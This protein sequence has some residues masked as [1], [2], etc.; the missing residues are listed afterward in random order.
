M[1]ML[2]NAAISIYI[3]LFMIIFGSNTCISGVSGQ[4]CPQ[5]MSCA[6]VP[7]PS[8]SICSVTNGVGSYT[9]GDSTCTGTG[10]VGN[11]ATDDPNNS[12]AGV[13][14]DTFQF[15]DGTTNLCDQ[16]KSACANQGGTLVEARG[17]IGGGSYKCSSCGNGGTISSL[18]SE[19]TS[20]ES[21]ASDNK[22]FVLKFFA[23]FSG[24][25]LCLYLLN[26]MLAKC[27]PPEKDPFSPSCISKGNIVKSFGYADARGQPVTLIEYFKAQHDLG[28]LIWLKGTSRILQ[29]RFLL[30]S[31]MI[32]FGLALVFAG[33]D[34]NG[35]IQ[36]ND[37]DYFSSGG[38]TRSSSTTSSS[39]GN[40]T[41]LDVDWTTTFVVTVLSSIVTFGTGQYADVVKRT[42]TIFSYGIEVVWV[43]ILAICFVIES[44]LT[45]SAKVD[46]KYSLYFTTMISSKVIGY[47]GSSVATILGFYYACKFLYQSEWAQESETKAR[48]GDSTPQQV[49][50]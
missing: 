12:G 13:S 38:T 35:V 36:A 50:V 3:A 32:S 26:T 9:C 42:P 45:E 15:T 14:C 37:C 18:A 29:L 31:F 34:V 23:L 39:G 28:K 16:L 46:N 20:A 22:G 25:A 49:A 5:I 11:A 24:I 2:H 8:R 6:E 48:E 41:S 30:Q 21:T 40:G 4:P 17:G 27:F 10:Q 7:C 47:F 1:I 43:I 44:G 33:I 19:G